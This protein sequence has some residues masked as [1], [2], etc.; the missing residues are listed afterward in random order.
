M[1]NLG[2]NASVNALSEYI[3]ASHLPERNAYIQKQQKIQNLIEKITKIFH[4]K[5]RNKKQKFIPILPS[6]LCFNMNDSTTYLM[7]ASGG[8]SMIHV[9]IMDG[10]YVDKIAGSINE[11]ATIRTNTNAHLHVHLMTESPSVWARDAINAGA[12]TVIIS[13]SYS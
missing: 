9:D 6:T 10:F 3:W 13:T 7:F 5:K 4:R 11:L 12:D 1:E 2:D 8:I